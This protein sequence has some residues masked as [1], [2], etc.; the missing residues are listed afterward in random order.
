MP[1]TS[2]AY[3]PP[4]PFGPPDTVSVPEFLFGD[5]KYARC[6]RAKSK[7][8]FTCGITGKSYSTAEVAERIEFLA[9]A[10]AAELGWPVNEGCELDKVVGIFSFN[11]IDHLTASWAVHR[12]S[13]V[14]NP[15]N[16]TYTTTQLVDQL[17]L[18]RCKA[19]FTC[20]A[21]L[22]RA[23]EAADAAGIPREHIYL[24]PVPSRNKSSSVAGD[25]GF[26]TVDQLI[27]E[28]SQL[29]PLPALQW[30]KGQG[31]RQTAFLIPSSGTSG[32]PKNVKV[33]HRNVIAHT[34]QFATFESVYRKG[35]PELGLGVLP[36]FH[37]YALLC[38]AHV[39]VHRGDGVVVLQ[40]FDLDDTLSAI[41][42]LRIGTLW[43]VP[44]MVVAMTKS[45]PF[46]RK[47]DLSSVSAVMV[48]SSPLT[49]ETASQFSELLPGR[50]FLQGYGLTEVCCVASFSTP[51][52]TVFGS[53]GSFLPGLE[54]RLIDSD[55]R[56]I[57]EPNQPGELLIRSPSVVLGY[58]GNETATKEMLTE[59]GWLRTGDLVEI[60]RSPK[61]HDHLFVVDRLKELIK[62]RGMQVAP[63]ELETFLLLSPMVADVCVVPY[64]NEA[65]GELPRAYIIRAEGLKGAED[66]VTR[67]QLHDYVND[68]F[69]EFKRLA[70]GIEFV[71]ALPKTPSGKTQR[72]VLKDRARAAYEASKKVVKKLQDTA[73]VV[74]Q[75]FEF[76]SEEDE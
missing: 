29:P 28:G 25:E 57:T 61:G 46:V 66:E 3:A 26:K 45:A 20:D 8:P 43:L 52:D 34:M 64:P 27:L 6:P 71:D 5:E 74:V 67:R 31:A 42:N 36:Q 48:G 65:A 69:P 55:G 51:A 63:A 12:L 21:L 38:I 72:K 17:T 23:L 49:R 33:S 59:D 24:L 19:L 53:C 7:P 10:L 40:G 60:R 44:S 30:E 41:Q 73:P 2:P 39:S 58:L 56:E 16:V 50:P 47:F 4:L 68:A 15:V 1:F 11:S 70:G 37:A 75:V 14:S 13:G 32:L 18:V 22:S 9:R 54:G 76:D 35:D 62:V